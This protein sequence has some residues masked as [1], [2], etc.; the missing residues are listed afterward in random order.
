ML[1][2]SRLHLYHYSSL[3]LFQNVA[4]A[5]VTMKGRRW[6]NVTKID[7]TSKQL[8]SIVDF[9][10][11]NTIYVLYVS[12]TYRDVI[13]LLDAV[14][15]FFFF[16]FFLLFF[17]FVLIKLNTS[18]VIVQQERAE[19]HNHTKPTHPFFIHAENRVTHG[20]ALSLSSKQ[21]EKVFLCNCR[22]R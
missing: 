14:I 5:R 21:R 18:S 9:P 1:N 2:F 16:L 15:S 22:F 6:K 12:S 19:A 7:R 13:A 11:V 4:F 10:A 17:S 3:I 8:H 20:R